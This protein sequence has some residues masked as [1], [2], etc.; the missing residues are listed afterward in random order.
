MWGLSLDFWNNLIV[1]F[2]A[3][4]AFAAAVVGVATYVAF[5]LQKQEARAANEALERYKIGVA[6]QVEEAKKE[7][8][9]AGKTAGNA[10]VRAATLEKE[11]ENARLETERL[12]AQLSWRTL[13]TE[14]AEKLGTE[15]SKHM[16]KVNLRYTDGDPEALFLAIQLSRV[17]GKAQWAIAPG[18]IKLANAISFG[19]SLPDADSDDAKWLRDAFS[20]ANIPF[21]TQPLPPMA[22]GFSI[23]TI[24][25]APTLMVGSKS[26]PLP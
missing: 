21:S 13:S 15:L 24:D 8:V 9:E 26:S 16:G 17:L 11:A 5:Q 14:T 22:A 10:I 6:A 12:K 3:L 18:S 2:L 23:S 19:I 4:G 1:G 7:G 20:A 25:G